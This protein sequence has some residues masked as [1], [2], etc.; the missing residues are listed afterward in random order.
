MWLFTNTGF[1]S[2]VKDG[3]SICVRARDKDSLAALSETFATPIIKT[4]KSD[5]PYRISL[6]PQRFAAWVK[7]MAINIDYRNFKS[8]VA[9][10]RG[11]EFS[12]PLMDVW[13]VMHQVEDTE[14]RI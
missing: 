2:A 5:Y 8:E 3:N 9:S 10:T 12:E 1:V 6:S 14:A 13:S 11:Y 7:H 4:P